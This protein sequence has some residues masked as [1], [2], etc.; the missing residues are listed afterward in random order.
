MLELFQNAH[1][2][3]RRLPHLLVLV[4]LLELLDRDDLPCLLVPAL[5]HDPVRALTDGAQVRQQISFHGEKHEGRPVYRS[6]QCQDWLQFYGS[7]RT[8]RLI[9]S[10]RKEC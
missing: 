10:V 9:D 3:Q 8:Y 6:A 5:E 4:A 7:A 1:L 2:P